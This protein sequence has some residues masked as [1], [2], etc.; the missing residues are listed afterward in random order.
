MTSPIAV[1]VSVE[2]AIQLRIYR[3]G[4]LPEV[5]PLTHRSALRLAT[6]LL[7]LA[8]GDRLQLETADER[9]VAR[10]DVHAPK[11]SGQG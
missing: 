9:R 11:S 3:S 8:A 1:A 4:G 5:V 10:A 2:G 6:D 7:N